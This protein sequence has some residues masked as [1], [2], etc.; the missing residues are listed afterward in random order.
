MNK[1]FTIKNKT[2]NIHLRPNRNSEL[3]SQGLFGE[4]FIVKKQKNFWFQGFLIRDEYNGWIHKKDLIMNFVPNYKV[5]A[6]KTIIKKKPDIKSETIDYL[7]MGGLVKVHSVT[8]EW[9]KIIIYYNKIGF[10]PT[11]HISPIKSQCY[12]IINQAVFMIGTPYLWG[13]K[14]SFGIDCS[15]K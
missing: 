2:A 7:S 3:V 1:K 15:W 12:N 13:G 6:V 4:S 5:L 14:S 11:N 10:I 8:D 9:A